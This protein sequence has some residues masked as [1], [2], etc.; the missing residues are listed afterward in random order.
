MCNAVP[1]VHTDICQRSFLASLHLSPTLKATSVV[2]HVL[3]VIAE[4]LIMSTFK[5]F[6]LLVSGERKAMSTVFLS[7]ALL[8]SRTGLQKLDSVVNYL[9]RSV[10]QIGFFATLWTVAGLT[11][12][13]LLPKTSAYLLFIMTV[14]PMYTHVGCS[15]FQSS[16]NIYICLPTTCR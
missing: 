14:G 16:S 10:I 3:Q 8:N 11:S 4:C 13:F 6:S 9:I 5:L 15:F 1:P 7:R 2:W 12:W